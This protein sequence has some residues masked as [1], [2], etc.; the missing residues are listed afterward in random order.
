[1]QLTIARLISLR[2]HEMQARDEALHRPQFLQAIKVF[3]LN[4]AASG[5]HGSH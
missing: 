2:S 4:L 3:R 1:M 5:S